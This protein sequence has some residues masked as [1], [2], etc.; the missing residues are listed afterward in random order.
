LESLGIALALLGGL[1][2]SPVF[3]F[4]L[5]RLIRPFPTLATPLF[6]AGVVGVAL[7]LVEASLVSLLGVLGTRKLVGP[8][9]FLTHVVL[10][11]SLAAALAGVLLLGKRSLSRLWPLAA[12]ICWIVGAG[13]IFYQYDVA[14]TLYGIDGTGGPYQ[15]PW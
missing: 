3:C 14:E 4:I 6:W 2:A 13:A 7:F 5:V 1:V 8:A 12:V 10:T 15:W 9:F 11:L